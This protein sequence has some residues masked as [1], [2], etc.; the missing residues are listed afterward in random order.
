MEEHSEQHYNAL[1]KKMM[2]ATKL[3]SPGPDF[4]ANIMQQLKVSQESTIAY[5]PPISKRAWFFIFAIVVLGLVSYV[6]YGNES[7]L[8]WFDNISW[9]YA[10]ESK[11]EQLL[12]GMVISKTILYTTIIFGILMFIQVTTLKNYFDKRLA[13]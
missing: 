2:K 9:R 11:L 3:D 5:K 1:A 12:S 10:E 13:T 8:G 7:S 6:L 4:T